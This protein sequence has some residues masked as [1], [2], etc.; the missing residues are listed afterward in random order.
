MNDVGRRRRASSEREVEKE[1]ESQTIAADSLRP[2]KEKKRERGDVTLIRFFLP[3]PVW[4]GDTIKSI[5]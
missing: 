1:R 4:R 2:E 3:I 5:S